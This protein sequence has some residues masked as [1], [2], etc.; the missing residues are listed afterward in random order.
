MSDLCLATKEINFCLKLKFFF[1]KILF[2]QRSDRQGRSHIQ[3]QKLQKLK[4]TLM[5]I[6]VQKRKKEN[7][8]LK[9]V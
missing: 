4:E 7:F 2:K 6:F 9:S 8:F 5:L 3:S 1:P